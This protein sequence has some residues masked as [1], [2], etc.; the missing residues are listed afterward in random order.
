VGKL[1]RTDNIDNDHFLHEFGP[2]AYRCWICLKD[3]IEQ[4]RED[5]EFMPFMEN[6]EWLANKA[7]EYWRRKNVEL[8]K[9]IIYDP[10]E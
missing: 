6:F 1:V 9:T 2:L 4:E 7:E 3:H 5:R 8:S 10:Q